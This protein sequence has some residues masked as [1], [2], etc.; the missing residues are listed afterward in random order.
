MKILYQVNC[1]W[2]ISFALAVVL[3]FATSTQ[4]SDAEVRVVTSNHQ[5]VGNGDEWIHIIPA[6]SS[7]SVKNG[8]KLTI[9]AIVKAH[10]G[11]RSVVA[12]IGGIETVELKPSST[13]FDGTVGM[14][15][16]EWTGR[17]LEEKNYLVA[18]KQP[19]GWVMNSKTD[20][21]SSPILSPVIPS[22]EVPYTRMAE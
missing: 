13:G 22:S 14:W 3:A 6:I 15:S 4:A 17:N 11:I 7:P 12:D 2:S 1:G 9:S 16:V 8:G 5:S 19:T 20:H 18:R 10:A 21:F